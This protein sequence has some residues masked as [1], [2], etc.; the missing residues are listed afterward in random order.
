MIRGIFAFILPLLGILCASYTSAE[1]VSGGFSV[2]PM[3]QEISLEQKDREKEFFITLANQTD[4][5]VSLS[6]S[7]LDFGSLDESGGVAFLGVQNDF[8]KK[9][10]LASWMRPEKDRVTIGPKE[11]QKIKITIENSVSLGPGGHYGAVTFRAGE[12]VD[13]ADTGTRIAVQQMFSVLV[14]AKK[15][16]G[17]RY[18]LT[19]KEKESD[20]NFITLPETVKLRFLNDG[21]VHTVPRGTVTITDPLGRMVSKGIINEESG[22]I[23]PETA[24]MYPVRIRSLALSFI[25]GYYML[26]IAYRYDGREE[27]SLYSERFAFLPGIAMIGISLLLIAATGWYAWRRRRNTGEYLASQADTP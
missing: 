3:F 12:G 25:P 15:I 6:L 9:Y 1:T 20:G 7:V 23:L 11:N 8:E 26:D 17:E 10:A 19:L 22:I 16:G 27:F 13:A 18:N 24:R 21:N 4:V 2:S 14:F 5:S